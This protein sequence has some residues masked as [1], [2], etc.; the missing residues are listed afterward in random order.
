MFGRTRSEFQCLVR[1]GQNF[2]V[3]KDR[4]RIAMFQRIR[5]E[6]QCLEG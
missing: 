4:A 1:Q 5:P 2:N 3:W 6:F